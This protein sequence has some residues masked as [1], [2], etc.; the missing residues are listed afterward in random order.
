VKHV[1][2]FLVAS[3]RKSQNITQKTDSV[4]A[5]CA[6]RVL[7]SKFSKLP[8]AEPDDKYYMLR[9]IVVRREFI[10]KSNASLKNYLHTLLTQHYPGYR[11]WFPNIDSK[12]SLA[13]FMRYPSP[14]TLIDTT[15]DELTAFIRE[16]SSN[17]T[18]IGRNSADRAR[19]ILDT[20]QDTSVPFQELRDD[21]VR[22]T[23]RQIMGN[24][25]EIT[26]LEK[27]IAVFM[28]QFE[29]T[30]TSMT[31]IDTVAAAQILSI[32][33]DIKKFPTPAKLARYSGVAPVTY[34]SGKKDKQYANRRG[35]RELNSILYLLAV[36]LIASASKKIINPFFREYYQRKITEGKTKRQALKCVQRRLV[37]IIWRMLTYNEEY[38][39]PEMLDKPEENM[40]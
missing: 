8:D 33:G 38:K 32:I 31:G 17:T 14:V 35:N 13:F 30:L 23:V 9:S 26:Q 4:D 6:A 34:A 16:A 25:A 27:T 12:T 28:K 2:A 20:L 5:E 10:I 15:L 19:I 29:C 18:G 24:M 11:N 39:K 36:R 7:L 37:N 1:N 22:S 21:A 3:E 40:V